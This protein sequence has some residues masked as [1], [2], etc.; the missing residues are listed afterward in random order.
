M[1][2]QPRGRAAIAGPHAGVKEAGRIVIRQDRLLKVRLS[3]SPDPLGIPAASGPSV[4][5]VQRQGDRR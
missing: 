3:E 5:A 4:A 1:S 2:V